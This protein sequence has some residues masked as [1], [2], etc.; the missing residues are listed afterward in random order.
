MADALDEPMDS[1]ALEMSRNLARRQT[2][3]LTFEVTMTKA[4]D[5]VLAADSS[6]QQ[7][8]IL[9]VEEV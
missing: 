6:E 2:R 5:H 1:Q 7:V 3:K 9:A 4:R 8:A